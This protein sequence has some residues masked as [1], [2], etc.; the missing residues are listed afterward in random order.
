MILMSLKPFLKASHRGEVLSYLSYILRKKLSE[1]IILIIF[2]DCRHEEQLLVLGSL[3]N[4]GPG[5]FLSR[6]LYCASRGQ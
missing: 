4:T 3:K 2:L 5:V 1:N 6:V